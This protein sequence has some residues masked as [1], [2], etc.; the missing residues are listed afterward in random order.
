MNP[1]E[2]SSPR[3]PLVVLGGYLGAGKTTL[4]NQ[5]LRGAAGRR[6]AV[7]VNDFGDVNIDAELI[8]GASNGVLALS[9]GCVCCSFGD[10]LLGGLRQVATRQ[11]APDVIL[12]ECSGVGLP[13]SVAQ[14]AALC[15]AVMVEGITVVLDASRIRALAQD[16]YVA[17]TVLQQLRSADLLLVNQM[18]RCASKALPALLD[19]L[20]KLAPQAPCLPCTHGQVPADLVLGLHREPQGRA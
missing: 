9:G 20:G 1:S 8:E 19:W 6:I 12:L 14:S 7:L 17:D 13:G 2:T 16:R 4:I 11:P 18:D 5:L 10:D 15:P 3:V